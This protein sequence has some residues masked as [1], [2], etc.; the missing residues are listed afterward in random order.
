MIASVAHVGP[1]PTS[2]GGMPAVVAEMLQSPLTERYRLEAIP[3]YRDRRPVRRLL[4]FARSLVVLA[5]WC[6]RR[7]P[8]I[9]HVHVAVRGSL[10]R[11]AIVVAV[12]KLTGRPVVLHVHAGP[13]DIEDFVARLGPLRLSAFRLAFAASDRVLSVSASSAAALRRLI[14]DVEITVVP[15]APPLVAATDRVRQSDA[16]VHVLYLGGYDDPAKGGSL[17]AAALPTVLEGRSGVRFTLAGPGDAP[18]DLPAGATWRGWLDAKAK[19]RALASADMFVL[20]S[21]SEGMP[22]ALLEAMARG[23]AIVAT[24]VGG[25]PEIL[26]DGVDA[27]LVEPN[28]A[29]ALAHAVGLVLDDLGLRRR[30]G[31]AAAERARKLADEDVYGRL[32]KVYAALVR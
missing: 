29:E 26:T 2:G 11:K 20:P 7:G 1:D 9:V 15:N 12:V 21:V 4:R 32:D 30:L 18:S 27:V 10:Y 24:R 31:E 23:L 16:G 14:T 6:L 8:R 22:V 3:T 25:V 5:R 17:L 13:G 19:E 28:D